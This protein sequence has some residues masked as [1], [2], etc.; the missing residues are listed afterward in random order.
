MRSDGLEVDDGEA[1]AHASHVHS[2]E[3]ITIV[4]LHA[5]ET[6]ATNGAVRGTL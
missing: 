5:G 4:D 1:V 3:A 6:T 2:P